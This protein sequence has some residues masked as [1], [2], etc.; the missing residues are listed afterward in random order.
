MNKL[1]FF[2]LYTLKLNWKITPICPDSKSPFLEKWNQTYHKEKIREYFED[3]PEF[4]LGLILGDLVDVEADTP[5]ANKFLDQLLIGSDH[6]K[7]SSSRSVH[8]LFI[9]PDKKLTKLSIQGIE[10]RGRLHQ[11]LLP[12]SKIKDVDYNWINIVKVPEMPKSL[13]NF[14]WKFVERI[15]RGIDNSVKIQCFICG[16]EIKMQEKRL[17]LEINAFKV[18]NQRWQCKKCRSNDIRPLCRRVRKC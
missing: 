18:L 9:N 13:S 6:P 11:S 7:W 15:I 1:E 3:N 2:D 12:P 10:F 4:N 8:H 5:S 16:K 17:N 14:Y